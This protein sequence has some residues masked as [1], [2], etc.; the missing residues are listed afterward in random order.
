MAE[1]LTVLA[2][3]VEAIERNV[4]DLSDADL[5]ALY[6]SLVV[7]RIV[8]ERCVRLQPAA[9]YRYRGRWRRRFNMLRERRWR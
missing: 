9:S 7:T 8:D 3:D 6:E 1:L 2:D 5:I 4:G